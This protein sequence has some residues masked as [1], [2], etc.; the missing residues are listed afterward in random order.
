MWSWCTCCLPSAHKT[1][2]FVCVS[3]CPHTP[4]SSKSKKARKMIYLLLLSHVVVVVG[5]VVVILVASLGRAP[6]PSATPSFC[7]AAMWQKSLFSFF[8]KERVQ[9]GKRKGPLILFFSFL[10]LAWNLFSFPLIEFERERDTDTYTHWQLSTWGFSH[11]WF[12]DKIWKWIF[13]IIFL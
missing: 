6:S 7:V 1:Q 12:K 13:L 10:F 8:G 4:Q 2:P 5:N 3:V 11:V 9:G